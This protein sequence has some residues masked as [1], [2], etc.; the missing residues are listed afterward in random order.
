MIISVAVIAAGCKKPDEPNNPNNE[1]NNS[2]GGNG[3]TYD[4]HEYVDLGLPS[5]TLWA[6][7]NVGANSPEDFGDYVSWGETTPKDNY[8]WR[9][10]RYGDFVD[11]RFEFTKYCTEADEGLNG[12]VDGLILLEPTDDAATANWGPDW[13]MPTKEEWHELYLKTTCTWT[14]QNGV[15]GRLLTGINGNAIFLPAAG[16][17]YDTELTGTGLGNYWSSSLYPDFPDRAWSFHFDLDYCHVCGSY[18]RNRG[19]VVRAVR[20]K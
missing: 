12:F 10:Y 6:T 3:G 1:G 16:C 19:H 11:A 9:S 14:T 4:V 20:S 2:G 17:H 7:C 18:E 8:D 15:D 5:G 13:R